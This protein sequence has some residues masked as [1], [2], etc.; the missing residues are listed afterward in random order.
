MAT[1]YLYPVHGS[2]VCESVLGCGLAKFPRG[3]MRV[4]AESQKDMKKKFTN[5]MIVKEKPK[6]LGGGGGGVC[7]CV[8]KCFPLGID[9]N[10]HAWWITA[11]A[12]R[13]CTKFRRGQIETEKTSPFPP[14]LFYRELRVK[15]DL[16]NGYMVASLDLLARH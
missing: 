10:A 5:K 13:S 12:T 6:D 2:T 3:R 11:N 7:V 1:K 4:Y 9:N 14:N 15:L 8:R 16:T